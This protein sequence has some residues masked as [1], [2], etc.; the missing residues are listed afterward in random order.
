MRNGY[1]KAGNLL[2]EQTNVTELTDMHVFSQLEPI[3]DAIT[4]KDPLKP[5]SWVGK[6]RARLR[7]AKSPLE[8]MLR[9]QEFLRLTKGSDQTT[10]VAYL[11][12]HLVEGVPA[13]RDKL[14]HLRA[15]TTMIAFM[16][17]V[18]DK[19]LPPRY[20]I[21]FS[22]AWW[23]IIREIFV[24]NFFGINGLSKTSELVTI[25][26]AGL[27]ALKHEACS[28][29]DTNRSTTCPVC[30]PVYAAMSAHIPFVKFATSKIL[31]QV[32]NSIM[33]EK[34]PPWCL[35][36]GS[37]VSEEVFKTHDQYLLDQLRLG[38]GKHGCKRVYLV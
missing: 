19:N 7:R 25:L 21:Y 2:A 11:R 37:V 8:Y 20:E 16:P 17:V 30:Y 34:N 33:D 22:D 13:D 28:N 1:R 15:F 4:N 35:S 27:R 5:L 6:N 31:C 36:N 10:A 32:T 12:K 26:D 38:N 29:Q 18:S 14:T 3:L 9:V 23:D 24:R